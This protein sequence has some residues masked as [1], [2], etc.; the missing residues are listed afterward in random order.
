LLRDDFSHHVRWIALNI[1][2]PKPQDGPT[3]AAQS[4]VHSSIAFDICFDFTT[5]VLGVMA[6]LE[7]T[8]PSLPLPSMPEV[9]VTKNRNI[10]GQDEVRLPNKCSALTG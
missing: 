4:I 6:T 8:L 1:C 10:W 7:F 9:A 3:C 5:P 2:L